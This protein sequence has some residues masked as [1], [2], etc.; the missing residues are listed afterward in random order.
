MSE[1]RWADVVDRLCD[2]KLH[3]ARSATHAYV[4]LSPLPAIPILL[5]RARS[6]VRHE[7]HIIDDALS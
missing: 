1:N 6:I 7:E 5:D 2:V 4:V 3:T